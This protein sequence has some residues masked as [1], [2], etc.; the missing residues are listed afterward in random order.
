MKGISFAFPK[1]TGISFA[2]PMQ[3]RQRKNE[4]VWEQK[5]LDEEEAN[6]RQRKNDIVWERKQLDEEE[7][8]VDETIAS[9]EEQS[10]L[11]VKG[12][13]DQ[14][15]EEDS[16]AGIVG[17]SD[18]FWWRDRSKKVEDVEEAVEAGASDV[19]EAGSSKNLEGVEDVEE[20]DM[21]SDMNEARSSKEL[22]EVEDVEEENM[23]EDWSR[24]N[25]MFVNYFLKKLAWRSGKRAH[26]PQPP[27]FP[28]EFFLIGPPGK[29]RQIDFRKV[30]I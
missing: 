19:N 14:E 12:E 17:F 10:R 8:K 21:A 16:K 11:S 25:E 4:I 9:L 28:P 26:C 5:Q 13:E 3:L 27:S 6:L 18:V 30:P 7:V 22:D 2:S 24:E 20:E 15:E 29:R 23:D 1:M